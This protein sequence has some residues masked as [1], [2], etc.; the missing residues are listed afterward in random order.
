VPILHLGVIDLPYADPPAARRRRRRT[1]GGTP[2]KTTGDIAEI[3]EGRY[4]IMELFMQLHGEQVGNDF[5]ESVSGAIESFIMGAPVS[6]NP[7]GSATSKLEDRFKQMLSTKEL[8]SLGYP[9]IPTRA[10]QLG[11]SKRFRHPYQRRAP[12]P[13]FIDTGQYQA[14]FKAWVE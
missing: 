7:F 3:L 2:N 10:A 12:R 4:H 1:K 9:G 14:S 13:S 5:A 6:I 11:H 8:D